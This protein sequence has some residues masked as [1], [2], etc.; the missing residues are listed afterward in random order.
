MTATDVKTSS[1]LTCEIK[2]AQLVIKMCL[3][4]VSDLQYSDVF[5]LA[6][7]HLLVTDWAAYIF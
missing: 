3:S 1:K 2:C 4:L 7:Q 5:F 6:H